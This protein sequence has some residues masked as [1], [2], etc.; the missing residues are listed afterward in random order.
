MAYGDV[1]PSYAERF[2]PRSLEPVGNT[3]LNV[4][5]DEM[6]VLAWAG[7]GGSLEL[8]NGDAELRVRAGP[9]P[10][11]P[12]ADATL[13]AVQAG[14]YRGLSIEFRSVSDRRESGLRVIER[15]ELAGI[16]IVRTPAYPRTS[17]EARAARP[18]F[19]L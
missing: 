14:E 1:A 3:W 4:N 19:W 15:A 7:D 16:S 11:I 17:I 9:L 18:R 2:E 10:R 6:A 13:A 8:D 12:L 5:H